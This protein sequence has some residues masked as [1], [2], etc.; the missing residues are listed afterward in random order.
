MQKDAADKLSKNRAKMWI[1]LD[2]NLA[3]YKDELSAGQAKK[4]EDFDFQ[5]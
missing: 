2:S 3:K 5:E 1:M 4:G